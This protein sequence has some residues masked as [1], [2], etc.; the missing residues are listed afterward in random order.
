MEIA[1]TML[2]S[3]NKINLATKKDLK[4]TEATIDI[5]IYKNENSLKEV[6]LRG[7]L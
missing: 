5:P 6:T 4:E 2:S 3:K 7:Q 1:A